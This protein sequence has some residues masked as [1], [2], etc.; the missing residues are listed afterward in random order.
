MH[1]ALIATETW[2]NAENLRLVYVCYWDI[3]CKLVALQ[4]YMTLAK[5][6]NR[7]LGLVSI[8]M[9]EGES[10]LVASAGQI[11]T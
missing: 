5:S 10:A 7:H 1:F 3:S 9:E 8:M 6:I 4:V 11:A 2:T